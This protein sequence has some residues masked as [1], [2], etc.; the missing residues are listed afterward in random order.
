MPRIGT[1]ILK[2]SL[3]GLGASSAY[4]LEGPPERPIPFGLSRAISFTGV[5]YFRMVQYT[6]HSRMRRAITWVYCE[7]KSKMTICSVMKKKR[8]CTA[9]PR[10]CERKLYDYPTKSRATDRL[11]GFTLSWLNRVNG[12]HTVYCS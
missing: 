7:P 8:V 6:L 12:N 4:A 2:I 1:P 9:F 3:S 10:F 5:S 11:G